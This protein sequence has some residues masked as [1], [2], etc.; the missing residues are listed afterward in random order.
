MRTQGLGIYTEIRGGDL[1]YDQIA[2]FSAFK[3]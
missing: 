2:A 1:A 3:L